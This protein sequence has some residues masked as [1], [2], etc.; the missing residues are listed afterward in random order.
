MSIR[1]GFNEL[2][3]K[4]VNTD[5]C[6]GCGACVTVCPFKDVLDYSYGKPLLIGECKNCGICPR[7]CPRYHVKVSE[8]D[9][10][11]FG[12]P[13]TPEHEFG[14][15]RDLYVARSTDREILERRQDGGVAT[16]LLVSALGSGLIDSAI[17]SGIEKSI[18]WFPKPM[19][20]TTEEEMVANAG[21]RYSYSPNILALKKGVERKFNKIG[22]IGTPCQ[23]LALRRMEMANLKKLTK[24]IAF[25]LGLFCSESFSYQGLMIEKIKKDLG[26][27]LKDVK[28]M[29]IKGKMFVY[30]KNGD[31]V[32]IP[33]KEIGIFA[34]TKCK[35]CNDFSAE[36]ADISLGGVGLNGWTFTVIR[37]ENGENAFNNAVS[38]NSLE[39]KPVS[40]SSKSL[41][42]LKLLTKI[43]REKFQRISNNK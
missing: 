43:K 10:F 13:R 37:T 20:V 21:T 38:N 39:V 34:E 27:D 4:I 11:V 15:Y 42:L 32:K 30:L 24:S 6:A 3:E 8:L 36:F 5:F 2:E 31:K 12:H 41:N 22:F 23:I 25:T 14:I 9:E 29:N 7:V 17:I 18:D 40:S 35:Y 28:K 33:L 1:L 26:I 16:T 19:V